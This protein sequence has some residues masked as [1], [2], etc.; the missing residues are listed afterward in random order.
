MIID[1]HCH[2]WGY[3]P[4]QDKNNHEPNQ[5]PVPNPE[6][7]GNLDQLVHEM[8]K[9]DIDYATVVSAQIWNNE[10]NNS[11]V[12]DTIKNHNNLFRK[13]IWRKYKNK[14]SQYPTIIF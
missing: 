4:Y 14:Y 1:S 7:W 13:I 10:E 2:A 9:N 12:R 3:W 11:Y 5:I 6:T 8:K